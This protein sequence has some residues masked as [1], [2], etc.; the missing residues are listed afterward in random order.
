MNI[1][2]K[3]NTDSATVSTAVAVS[4]GMNRLAQKYKKEVVPALKKEFDFK[5]VMRV[6]KITKVIVHV[7]T[8]KMSKDGKTT[9]KIV[10]DLSKITGQK[11]STRVAKKSISG[12]KLREG[13]PVG[14]MVTLRGRRMY[15]FID[16]LISIAL[17]RSRDFQ[18]LSPKTMD[19][20]G[21]MN[22]GIKEHI[23]FPEVSYESLRDVF[24]LQVTIVT[25]AK[26]RE[27]GVRLLRLMG[28]PI[29]N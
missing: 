17:P 24:G 27:E 23:I 5:N 28:F 1:S 2:K 21:N 22:I 9:D 26:N 16:R 25:T 10:G 29:R 12:F 3:S 13:M 14:L 19:Q 20:G 4:N 11:P 8:G 18:G 15:D 7:G 6:P